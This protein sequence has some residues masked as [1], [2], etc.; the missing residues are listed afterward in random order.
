M[1]LD[2][3]TMAQKDAAGAFQAANHTRSFL[4]GLARSRRTDSAETIASYE[5]VKE[6]LAYL[7]DPV[8]HLGLEMCEA[9]QETSRDCVNLQ[10]RCAASASA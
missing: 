8:L 4:A 7:L 6:M 5:L 2:D 10:N 9:L 3:T 1:R